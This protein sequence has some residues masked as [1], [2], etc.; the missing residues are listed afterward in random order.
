MVMNY[1]DFIVGSTNKANPYIQF[2][3]ITD[4]AEGVSIT[5]YPLPNLEWITDDI[6]QPMLTLSKRA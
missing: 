2:L 1:G 4:P 6:F 5:H 3:S